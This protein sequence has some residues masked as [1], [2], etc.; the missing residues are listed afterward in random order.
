MGG[1]G[2]LGSKKVGEGIYHIPI[3]IL[4]EYIY[5]YT[6]KYM[7]IHVYIMYLHIHA[8]VYI[9][10][11][12]YRVCRGALL[13]PSQGGSGGCYLGP[14]KVDGNARIIFL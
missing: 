6:Y 12:I 2:Y 1:G 13:W 9:M 10:Y 11:Y 8:Y 5:L 7:Y 3:E 4:Y 14:T